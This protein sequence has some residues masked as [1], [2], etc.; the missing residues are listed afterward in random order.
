MK[1][2]VEEVEIPLLDQVLIKY[3]IKYKKHW[4]NLY[5]Y[6]LGEGGVPH[7]YPSEGAAI[8]DLEWYIEHD[9]L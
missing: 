4:W 5:Q 3:I 1:Y 6:K 8:A 7:L 9:L 2:K